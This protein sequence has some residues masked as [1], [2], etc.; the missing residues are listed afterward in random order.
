MKLNNVVRVGIPCDTKF[1]REYNFANGRF[2]LFCWELIFAICR[3]THSIGITTFWFLFEY[4]Q[5]KYR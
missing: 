5:L 3:K 4:M 1:L 2:F